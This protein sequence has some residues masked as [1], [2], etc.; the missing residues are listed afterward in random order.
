MG[1]PIKLHQKAGFRL[2][3]ELS[4]L[5]VIFA[6]VRLQAKVACGSGCVAQMQVL[7]ACPILTFVPASSS[8]VAV[9]PVSIVIIS[10]R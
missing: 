8:V 10:A 1:R 3:F 4:V 2:G 9:A 5:S 6:L 7:L